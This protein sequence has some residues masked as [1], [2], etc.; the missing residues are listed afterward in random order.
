MKRIFL[1]ILLLTSCSSTSVDGDLINS[2]SETT[3][4]SESI[5]YK[6]EEV[7]IYKFGDGLYTLEQC[8]EIGEALKDNLFVTTVYIQQIET[9]ND[10]INTSDN[11]EAIMYWDNLLAFKNIKS[12]RESK[13][14]YSDPYINSDSKLFYYFE[15]HLKDIKNIYISLDITPKANMSLTYD[16]KELSIMTQGL[17]K[18]FQYII[19]FYQDNENLYYLDYSHSPLIDKN[20]S[21][22][23]L[24]VRLLNTDGYSPGMVVDTGKGY[25]GQQNY[26]S[27]AEYFWNNLVSSYGYLIANG[28]YSNDW[29][30]NL[31]DKHLDNLNEFAFFLNQFSECQGV[32]TFS[33]SL[34]TLSEQ[35]EKIQ[36]RKD[37]FSILMDYFPETIIYPN[38]DWEW[39]IDSSQINY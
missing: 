29:Y 21:H 13:S 16:F 32:L 22:N 37:D 17:D 6:V 3:N 5:N 24:L 14:P 2:L 36:N 34:D 25:R 8:K 31:F 39:S 20:E 11:L 12:I 1:L 23:K 30:L 7:D 28:E 18:E 15:K 19:E 4:S 38:I 27:R 26:N 10:Y 9:W 35:Y 33:G